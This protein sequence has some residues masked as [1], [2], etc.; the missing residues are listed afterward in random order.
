MGDSSRPEHVP[1]LLIVDDNAQNLQLLGALLDG[2]LRCELCFATGGLEALALLGELSPD[3]VL[4]DVNMPELDGYE[5]CRRLRAN[6]ATRELPVIFI[7]AQRGAEHV[8]RGFEAGGSDYV[9]KP[10]ETAE[11][12]ARVRAQLELKRSRDAL[13]RQKAE[14]EARKA[15]LEAALSRLRKLEGIVPVCMHCHR[16][17]DDGAA[18]HRFEQYLSEHSE[19]VFSHGVC[20]TCL[21]AHYDDYSDV[22]DDLL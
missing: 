12:L 17:R 9:C 11:L 8:V 7:T 20:P 15:E 6:P 1:V 4:L 18:W 13:A 5:V 22:D 10:F 19:A 2:A 3:L 14:L 21:E 16:I